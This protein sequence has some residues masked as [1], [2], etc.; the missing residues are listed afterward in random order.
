VHNLKLSELSIDIVET[1]PTVFQATWRGKS[2]ER[3]PGEVLQSWL[4]ALLA[5][6][7][8]H[9]GSIEMHFEHI[10]HFNSSTITVLV[11]LIQSCRARKVKLVMV[12]NKALKWQTLSFD[13]LRIFVLNDDL[14]VLRAA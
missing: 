7:I 10:E 5:T 13:A 9:R 2:Y 8:E 1:P 6:A 11:R 14:F 3:N 12:Y 4:E